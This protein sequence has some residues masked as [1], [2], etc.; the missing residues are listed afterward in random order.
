MCRYGLKMNTHKCA[1]GVMA[2][3]FLGFII[4]EH[5]IEVDPDQ[6]IAIR[7]LGVPTCELEM[8]KFLDKVNYL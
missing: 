5:D 7:N 2:R 4:H 6:I 3:K 8:Q 1:F